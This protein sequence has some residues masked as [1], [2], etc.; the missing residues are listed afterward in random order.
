MEEEPL[1][2]VRSPN[3]LVRLSSPNKSTSTIEVKDMYAAE[4]EQKNNN[5]DDSQDGENHNPTNKEP[6][7]ESNCDE[8]SIGGAE[9][10]EEDA[11]SGED[12]CNVCHNQGVNLHKEEGIVLSQNIGEN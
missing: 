8:A 4:K 11:N 7:A 3:A 12:Y 2:S 5:N 6:E 1:K 9:G 10:E